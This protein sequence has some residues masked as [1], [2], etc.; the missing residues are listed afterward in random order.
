MRRDNLFWG[1]V[2]I[3]VGVLLYLQAQGIINNVFQYFWPLAM[4]LVGIWLILGVYWK[5]APSPGE[6]FSIPLES[7]QSIRYNFSHGAGQLEIGGGAPVG[8]ALVGNS[9]SGMNKKS[10]LNGD[11][12]EVRVEAGPTWLPFIGPSEGVWKFQLTR[13][14]PILLTVETGASFLNIDLRDVSVTH[15]ALKT[16]ASS[17]NIT[18]P[19]RG[20][21]LL[22]VEAGAAT[23]NI[24]IPET[25][26]ARIRAKGVTALDVDTN[27]F[28]LVESGFYQSS[29]FDL[30]SD[31]AEINIETGLG[32]ITVK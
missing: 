1:V 16:G 15:F 14:L 4:L 24:F 9:A 21:S 8:Q 32:K 2:L 28:P 30:A 31:R 10:R 11:Q 20:V 3:I 6:V 13:E 23:I 17:T 18:M 12:L 26:A 22:D 5:P 25:A 27:R 29:N 19:A 7:A